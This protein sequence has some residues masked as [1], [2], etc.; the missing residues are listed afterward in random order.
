M[1]TKI[2]KTITSQPTT[3]RVMFLFLITICLLTNL[4]KVDSQSTPTI[5]GKSAAIVPY[6]LSPATAVYWI[7]WGLNHATTMTITTEAIL[8]DADS[9]AIYGVAGSLLYLTECLLIAISLLL[10][11]FGT[12]V[13]DFLTG[14][15][16]RLQN[17]EYQQYPMLHFMWTAG[18]FVYVYE[19]VRIFTDGWRWRNLGPWGIFHGC[20]M[21]AM[22]CYYFW[23]TLRI[24]WDFKYP[25]PPDSLPPPV[26]HC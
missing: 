16:C 13:H 21:I 8:K 18:F 19:V 24:A 7:V 1:V 6:L 11:H 15:S 2:K 20:G 14:R 25:P 26:G 22:A 17:T 3:K 4:S 23:G 5:V 9:P 10:A 12:P